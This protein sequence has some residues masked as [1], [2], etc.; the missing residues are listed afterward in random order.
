RTCEEVAALLGLPLARTVKSVAVIF[1]G[2]ETGVDAFA[3]LLVRGDHVVNEIKL[4]QLTGFSDYRLATEEEI[5]AHLGSR[6][7]FLG[8]LEPKLPIRIIADRSLSVM[9]DVVVGANAE[10]Y[11]LAGVNFG[12][13]LPEPDLVADIRNV[14]EGDRSPDGNGRLSIA[15]GIEVGHVFQLGQKY[16]EA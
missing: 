5:L 9:A 7:G 1:R 4:A 13:D 8:P 15:R 11:H 3:L 6:P 10:G 14:V 12:R 2:A 16:A